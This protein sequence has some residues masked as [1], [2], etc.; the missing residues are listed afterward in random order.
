M[1]FCLRSE[2]AFS[3]EVLKSIE[4]ILLDITIS[5]IKTKTLFW[6]LV[7][8]WISVLWNLVLWNFSFE[9]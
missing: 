3:E 5:Y 8:C 2:F 4:A 9:N 7:L 1:L 6:N